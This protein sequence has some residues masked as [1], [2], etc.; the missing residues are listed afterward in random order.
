MKKLYFYATF[1]SHSVPRSCF[2]LISIV[3][4]AARSPIGYDAVVVLV[5]IELFFAF[6]VGVTCILFSLNM[7][8]ALNRSPEVYR[9]L[10]IGDFPLPLPGCSTM[11]GD[12]PLSLSIV[13]HWESSKLHTFIFRFRMTS[14]DII[15]L[16]LHLHMTIC[17]DIY[18]SMST[19]TI[20][21]YRP[22]SVQ[23]P[24]WSK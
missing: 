10:P 21:L 23:S 20:F 22:L 8:R 1:K 18:T 24:S 7:F 13:E 16:L 17:V 5:G 14:S 2:F 12:R 19:F 6:A 3:N 15:V 11:P 4:A 9:S